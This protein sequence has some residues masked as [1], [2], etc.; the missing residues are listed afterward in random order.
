GAGDITVILPRTVRCSDLLHAWKQMFLHAPFTKF[1]KAKSQGLNRSYV[2]V[3]SSESFHATG[4]DFIP[5]PMLVS[6]C[7]QATASCISCTLLR[8]AITAACSWTR[9]FRNICIATALTAEFWSR[10]ACASQF[11]SRGTPRVTS[12]TRPERR[13]HRHRLPRAYP[14]HRNRD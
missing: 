7:A 5:P 3:T 6:L 4:V 11:P 14:S 1:Q 12:P 2:G 10:D 9:G 13:L 8:R